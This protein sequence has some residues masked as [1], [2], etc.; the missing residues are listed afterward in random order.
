MTT[1]LQPTIART[2]GRAIVLALL[3]FLF[4]AG[5][6]V[7]F[8]SSYDPITDAGIQEVVKKTETIVADVTVNQTPYAQHRA[9]YREVQGALAGVALRAGLYG[10]KNAAEQEIIGKLQKSLGNLE[11]IH[12]LVGP[13][14]PEEAR[15]TESLLVSLMHHELSK[16]RS[17]PK[18]A[19]GG[20]Q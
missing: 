16:K 12:R 15:L 11:K 20:A 7:S 6:A 18:Q 3:P 2:A 9:G 13:F 1:T 17:L 4:L 10:E 14:R 8:V 5:C 19:Q